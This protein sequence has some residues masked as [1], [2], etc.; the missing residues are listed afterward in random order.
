MLVD[1]VAAKEER[2]GEKEELYIV[3]EGH[4][5]YVFGVEICF[6]LERADGA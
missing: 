4:F 3:K 1:V 2:G 6:F 5:A